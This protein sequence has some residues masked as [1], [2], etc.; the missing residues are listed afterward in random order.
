MLTNPKLGASWEGFA[1]EATIAQLG[2]RD[3]EVFF[4]G[5]HNRVELDLYWQSN[6]RSY[7]AEFKYMDAPKRT[8]SMHQAIEDLKLA[9]LYVIYPGGRQYAL[10]EQITVLPAQ[11]LGNIG[12]KPPQ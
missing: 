3:N 5:T 7:G 2:K 4:Y 6:G 12:L 8:K 11:K 9:Y 10:S 1:I